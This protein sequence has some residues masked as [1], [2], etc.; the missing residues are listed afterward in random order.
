VIIDIFT[1]KIKKCT[2]DNSG[3]RIYGIMVTAIYGGDYNSETQ[4]P[5][6]NAQ[7]G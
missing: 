2:G 1:E 6:W 7:L 4:A 3:G 5:D